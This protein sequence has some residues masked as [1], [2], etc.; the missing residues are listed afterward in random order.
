[1]ITV[2]S[3]ELYEMKN[4]ETNINRPGIDIIFLLDRSG[5]NYY[6]LIMA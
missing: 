5:I 3:D 1:M 2:K 6:F 4:E